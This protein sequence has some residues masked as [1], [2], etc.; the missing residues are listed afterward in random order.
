[1]GY[2]V[3]W[4]AVKGHSPD[5]VMAAM[6]LEPGDGDYREQAYVGELPGGWTLYFDEDFERGFKRPLERIV[7][8]GAAVIAARQEDHVMYSEARGFDGGRE[9]WRVVRDPDEMPETPLTVTGAPPAPFEEIRAKAVAKQEIEDAGDANVCYIYDV[10]LDLAA[11]ACGFR[12]DEVDEDELTPV[13]AIRQA[14]TGGFFA[15]LFGR[16]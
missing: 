8:L 2:S 7:A 9:I 1:M 10:P 14:P 15:R 16:G 12:A 11:A 13:V 6:G 5:A 4:V 3:A